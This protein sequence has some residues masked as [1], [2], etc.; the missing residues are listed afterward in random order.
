L[1]STQLTLNQGEALVEVD[2]IHPEN[3]IRITENGASTRLEKTGLYAFDATHNIVRV[4]DGMAT[5]R[6][7]D[8]NVKVKGG[9]ELALSGNGTSKA[10]K[11]DKKSMQATDLYRWSSL[12]SDYLADANVQ[13]ARVYY[14]DGWYGPEWFGAG[15]Y[16][17]P[18]YSAYTFIPGDGIF[19]N[20]FGWGFYSPLW[21]YRAPLFFGGRYSRFGVAP[22]GVGHS[23]ASYHN[24]AIHNG[25]VSGGHGF[26][27][28]SRGFGA[29]SGGGGGFHGGFAG[30]GSHGGGFGGHR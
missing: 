26:S 25:F 24:R 10:R 11:F 20:P 14:A 19:Y 7:N 5:V 1:T 17:S 21:A 22:V 9:H 28:G 2:E 27:G 29:F 4:F 13:A 6:D 16:W 15:W 3:E 18:W 12:R 30:G 23:P 8:R